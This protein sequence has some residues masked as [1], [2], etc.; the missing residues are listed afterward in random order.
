MH[1]QQ[2]LKKILPYLQRF[3]FRAEVTIFP[4]VI[5]SGLTVSNPTFLS[6]QFRHFDSQGKTGRECDTKHAGPSNGKVKISRY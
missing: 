4:L 6:N 2:N 1:G 5:H 3:S